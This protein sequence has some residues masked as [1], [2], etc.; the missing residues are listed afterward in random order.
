MSTAPPAAGWDEAA[1]GDALADSAWLAAAVAEGAATADGAALVD[2]DA[3][4][5]GAGCGPAAE[6]LTGAGGAYVYEA[7]C[8]LAVQADAIATTARPAA[9]RVVMRGMSPS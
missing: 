9:I 6:L 8:P 2:A 1:G 4:V 5:D 3:E 7:D